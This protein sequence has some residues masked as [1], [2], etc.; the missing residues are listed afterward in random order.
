MAR[1]RNFLLGQ[2]ERLASPVER[3]RGGSSKTLPYSLDE[4]KQRIG[5]KLRTAAEKVGKL[6]KEACPGDEAVAILT[7]HPRY[8]SKSD[9]PGRLLSKVGLRAVGSRSRIIRPDKWGVKTHPDQARTEELF[10]AGSRSVFSDWAGAIEQWDPMDASSLELRHVEDL[11]VQGPATKLKLKRES[12]GRILLEA[13]VHNLPHRD[14]ASDFY[15]FVESIGG[16]VAIERRRDVGQLIFLP[17]E[18]SIDRAE[19]VAEFSFLRVV[20][21]MPT[22]R[23]FMPE[24]A[25]NS[26]ESSVVDLPSSGPLDSTRR[27]VIFDGGIPDSAIEPLSP[28]VS[29]VEP[30]GLGDAVPELEEHGLGVTAAFLFGQLG[31]GPST[32]HP[33][34]P[35]DH[36]RVLDAHSV[37]SPDYEYF[38]ALDRI[39]T[40]LDANPDRY[41]FVNLSLGPELAMDDDEIT[42]WTAA[43]DQRMA[44]LECITTVAAGNDGQL[45]SA[46][47]LNRIQPPADGVNILSVG[48]ADSI[49]EKW[50]R[51]DYSCV[52]PGRCP[53]VFKPDGIAF[54]GCEQEPFRVLGPD[55]QAVGTFGTSYAA[56][57]ALRSAAATAA[58]IGNELSSLAIRALLVHTASNP[59]DLEQ[60][61]VG[62]GR[63]ESNAIRLITCNDNEV[64]VV[65]QGV[66]PVG[67][68]LRIPVPLGGIDLVGMV[69]VSATLAIKPSVDPEHPG[70][71]TRG[72]LEVQFRPHS[73][74][75]ERRNDGTRPRYAK[76]SA[77]FSK[78][79]LFA[80][81][82]VEL[83]EDGHK[84]EP[85][86]R[87]SRK[88]R[89]TSLNEPSFD[90]YYHH[91][92]RGMP[93]ADAKPMPYSFIVGVAA[94]KVPDLYNSFVRENAQILVPLRPSI[95]IPVRALAAGT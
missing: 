86:V 95:R 91:R 46:A 63:F 26:S 13:V 3:S 80:G 21:S 71:Y 73:A 94:K 45:D 10:V 27:A 56:P 49:E 74:R 34:C 18:I 88:Y 36:V 67:E 20:R 37:E 65:Y 7:L 93:D 87:G 78:K 48:A 44:D 14:L 40:F 33:V 76:P 19:S 2:G 12:K 64:K 47:M 4:S 52:G 9:F 22:L 59:D 32:G 25:L 85:C 39:L 72:G 68:S 75:F 5:Q 41:D 69:E 77:F 35:V 92:D 38:D 60:A 28:W 17:V 82:E 51:A 15:Q 81:S 29:L 57:L 42:L 61:Q 11:S 54:G 6:P 43:I 79:R 84:W 66:L 50:K 30:D 55:L 90:I 31:P 89:A 58:Q 23:S 8:I 83:R 53:G 24:V 62:W 1:E 70:A 16:E